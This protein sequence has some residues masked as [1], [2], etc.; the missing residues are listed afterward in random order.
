MTLSYANGPGYKMIH[1][2][3]G[4]R[5]NFTGT[6]FGKQLQIQNLIFF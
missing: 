3:D 1:N 4:T 5:K 6:E 2:E